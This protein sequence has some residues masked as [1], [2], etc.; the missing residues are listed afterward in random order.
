MSLE[1]GKSA[2]EATRLESIERE[3][4]VSTDNINEVCERVTCLIT[5]LFGPEP[6]RETDDK[7]LVT[8]SGGKVGGL[9]AATR[10]LT[11]AK[12]RL[13][14]VVGTLIDMNL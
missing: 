10:R 11:L 2:R 12:E 1:A 9:D 4:N 3:I 8:D 14:I 7:P 6:P 5:E 13:S